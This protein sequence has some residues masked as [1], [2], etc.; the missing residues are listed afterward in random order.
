MLPFKVSDSTGSS[1]WE[2]FDPRLSLAIAAL[3]PDGYQ[4]K[5]RLAGQ[6][7]LVDVAAADPS[8]SE[9]DVAEPTQEPPPPASDEAPAADNP[10]PDFDEILRI[11]HREETP[12]ERADRNDRVGLHPE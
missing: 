3:M 4:D 8:G 6:L 10:S 11:L 5:E 7:G 9:A 2:A 12:A 1:E